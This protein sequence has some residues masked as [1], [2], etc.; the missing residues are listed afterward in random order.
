[1]FSAACTQDSVELQLVYPNEQAKTAT[2]E[3]EIFVFT[4]DGIDGSTDVRCSERL[5]KIERG[6]SLDVDPFVGALS[7]PF[8]GQ[9]ILNFPSGNPVVFVVGYRRIDTE[10]RY[11]FLEGC[12]ETF[13]TGSDDNIARIDLEMI[14]PKEVFLEKEE[15][16]LQSNLL[17]QES[18]IPLKVRVTAKYRNAPRKSALYALPGLVLTY[19]GAGGA[20]FE[21]SSAEGTVEIATGDE[22]YAEASIK[23]DSLGVFEVIVSASESLDKDIRPKDVSFRVS[24]LAGISYEGQV[25]L[26]E[27]KKEGQKVVG[28]GIGSVMGLADNKDVVILSCEGDVANCLPGRAAENPPGNTR[29][30]I[31]VDPTMDA[32]ASQFEDLDSMDLGI[33]PAGLV[34]TKLTGN[35][36]YDD[37]AFVNSRHMINGSGGTISDGSE[38]V[39]LHGDEVQPNLGLTLALNSSNAVGLVPYTHQN[40]DVLP[41]LVTASQGRRSNPQKC[42]PGTCSD[43][44]GSSL[45]PCPA[46]ELCECRA[47]ETCRCVALDRFVDKI[48]NIST[49]RVNFFNMDK[50]HE[51]RLIC[52]KADPE[53]RTP[54]GTECFCDDQGGAICPGS[55]IDY[56]RCRVPRRDLIGSL[57]NAANPNH[58]TSGFLR[59]GNS[60][61]LIVAAD[62]GLRFLQAISSGSWDDIGFPILSDFPAASLIANVN[63]DSAKDVIWYSTS[64]CNTSASTTCVVQTIKEVEPSRN[65]ACLGVLPRSPTDP[66]LYAFKDGAC[67]TY[68][69]SFVP[70]SMCV[71]HMN[72]DEGTDIALSGHDSAS[73]LLFLG[74]GL[75]G[76]LTEPISLAL[77]EGQVGGAMECED[78]NADGLDE[79]TVVNANTGD[80]SIFW[81]NK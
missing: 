58:L 66:G 80:V 77:P 8:A 64:G 72:D 14:Q 74:N 25:S 52:D 59:N 76:F 65:Q 20:T 36:A 70:S 21:H 28:V 35:D 73:I 50:C 47:D 12:T 1:M 13:N 39:I 55:T 16:D 41:S 7:A 57:M 42:D 48:V 26:H 37:I 34:V 10:Q 51:P 63:E 17:T 46:G 4:Q 53:R 67:R 45:A 2:H 43:G 62:S 5:G 60:E 27:Q 29:L 69:L 71:G 23:T 79:I 24:T 30:S 22:G 44:Q 40:D 78:L 32:M 33:G 38:V 61:D 3:L 49:D 81:T 31:L 15:G 6:E 75:G 11:E 56:C 54:P 18:T 68:P 9:E 19:Q